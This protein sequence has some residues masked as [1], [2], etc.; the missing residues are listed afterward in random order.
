MGRALIQITTTPSR[1]HAIIPLQGP[2]HS[3]LELEKKA[4]VSIKTWSAATHLTCQRL[5]QY[6]VGPTPSTIAPG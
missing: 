1:I 3:N 2:N 4:A 6:G 5:L